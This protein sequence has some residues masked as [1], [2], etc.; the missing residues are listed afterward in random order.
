MPSLTGNAFFVSI[1]ILAMRATTLACKLGL[2]VFVGSQLDLSALGIYGLAV[3]AIAFGP[4]IVGLGMV[5][6]IMR[7]AVTLPLDQLVG[8]LRHYWYFTTSI[9]ALILAFAAGVTYLLDVSWVFV[10]IIAITLFEHFGND[11]FQLLSNLERPLLANANAFLR[12]TAWIL[13]YVPLAFWDPALQSLSALFAL[14]LCGSVL[15]FLQFMWEA[16]SWPWGTAFAFPS[17]R[18][19]LAANVRKA[20]VIYLADLGY[21]ASQYLDRYLVTAF[22]GL[23]LGGIYFLYWSVAN[24]VSTFVSFVVLQIQRPRLVRAFD[25]SGPE[26]HLKLVCHT[27]KITALASIGFSAAVAAAFYAALPLLK[28]PTAVGDYLGAFALIMAGMALRNVADLGAMGLFTARRDHVM[29]LTIVTSVLALAVAQAAL[30]P[31]AGLHG[32]GAAIMIAFAAM[33]LW[34]YQLLFGFTAKP[35]QPRS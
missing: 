16:R 10:V 8:H 7:D 12:S 14:W 18:S 17:S 28:Q 22:L 29:T 33:I 27:M 6:V 21:V 1:V 19:W 5:H 3:G 30:L 26:A 15:A 34:R 9:Y 4:A 25:E 11:V 2:T 31:I 13:I 24:A 32:A 20:F 23:R 35:A